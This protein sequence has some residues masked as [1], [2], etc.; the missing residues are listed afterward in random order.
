VAQEKQADSGQ[1]TCITKQKCEDLI[2]FLKLLR[3]S[4]LPTSIFLI[5]TARRTFWRFFLFA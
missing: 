4:H 2:I 1:I 3:I 5:N